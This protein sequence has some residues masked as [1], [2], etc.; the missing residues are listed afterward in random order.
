[1][2]VNWNNPASI[3]ADNRYRFVCP[4]LGTE[5]FY[6]RCALRKH[7][8]WRGEA[9]EGECATCMKASKCAA[10]AMLNLEQRG[11][12]KFFD[13]EI[14][15]HRLPKVVFDAIQ[16]KLVRPFHGAGTG[17]DPATLAALVRG[18]FDGK[19]SDY[20]WTPANPGSP[21]APTDKSV[22]KK[23][24]PKRGRG[25]DIS[26]IAEHVRTDMAGAINEARSR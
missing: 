24:V 4:T 2:G 15:P 26:D 16:R 20:D 7:R 10:V 5:Q 13:T 1:M 3:T 18:D 23:D 17:I 14:K 9:I 12:A 11:E 21:D 19:V 22:V 25:R 8:Q 6:L